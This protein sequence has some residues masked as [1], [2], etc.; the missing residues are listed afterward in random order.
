MEI[1][2]KTNPPPVYRKLLSD[3]FIASLLLYVLFFLLEEF[4]SGFV[5]DHINLNVLLAVVFISGTVLALTRTKITESTGDMTRVYSVSTTLFISIGVGILG[6]GIVWLR[7]V[8]TLGSLATPI[9]FFITFV[10]TIMIFF[11]LTEDHR[12]LQDK[13]Q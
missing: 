11:L 8:R 4:F 2:P 12:D 9:S 7:T 10:I 5:V 3:I 6:G 13:D 1:L